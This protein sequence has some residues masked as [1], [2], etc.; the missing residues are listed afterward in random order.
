MKAMAFK[1]MNTSEQN[2]YIW[3]GVH[4]VKIGEEKWWMFRMWT[5]YSEIFK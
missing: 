5:L 1:M 4:N 2:L 3:V